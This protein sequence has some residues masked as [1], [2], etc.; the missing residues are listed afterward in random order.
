MWTLLASSA[1][2]FA[3]LFTSSIE[4]FM[5]NTNQGKEEVIFTEQMS[6]SVCKI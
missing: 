5:K 2:I 4:N 1:R 6:L 3:G